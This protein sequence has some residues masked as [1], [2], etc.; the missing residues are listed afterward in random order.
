M[1]EAAHERLFTFIKYGMTLNSEWRCKQR[2]RAGIVIDCVQN[3][4]NGK[5]RRLVFS[6]NVQGM[7]PIF[8][9][10]GADEANE[11]LLAIVSYKAEE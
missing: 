8:L 11:V 9:G 4:S 6:E 5:T 10:D 7:E 2:H 3:A 1:A